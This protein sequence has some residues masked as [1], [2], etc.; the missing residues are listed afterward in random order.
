MFFLKLISVVL[1]LLLFSSACSEDPATGP[2]KQYPFEAPSDTVLNPFTVNESLGRGINMGNALEA[3]AEGEWGVTIRDNYFTEIKN[4]GFQSVRIPIRWNAHAM[5]DSPYTIDPVFLNRV[6]WVLQQALENDL[7][8]IF[9]I[10]HYT[11]IFSE[12]EAQ[13]IR[14]LSIWAQIAEH[15]QKYPDRVIFEILNEP[16][17][18]LTA[19]LWND[20]LAEAIEVIRTTNPYRTLM[21]GMAEWGGI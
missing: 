9:N 14:F 1:G 20:F 16:H 19:E 12:P 7:A 4:A 21:I 2:G 17:D 8:L 5:A 13:K 6:D 11:D 15:Y 18:N 3:P 10:H